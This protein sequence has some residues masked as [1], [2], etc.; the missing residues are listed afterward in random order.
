MAIT[1]H[2]MEN[3]WT[4]Y[5]HL[6]SFA[7]LPAPHTAERMTSVLLDCLM[8]W[9]IDSKISTITL[10]NYST[11]ES[12]IDKVKPKLL[13]AFLIKDG[14]MLH[15]R[16]GAHILNFTVRDGLLVIKDSIV[17]IR[18]SVA[19]WLAT[20]RRLEKIAETAKQLGVSLQKRLVL[21]CPTRWNSTHKMLETAIPNQIVFKRL[22]QR[23][24]SYISLPD[25]SMWEFPASVC[26][27]LSFC[28]PITK[29]FSGSNYPTSNVFF[30]EVCELKLRLFE[31]MV[32]PN[33]LISSMAYSM[34]LKFQKYWND[35]HD[36][37]TVAAVLDPKFKLEL[38][39]YYAE[40]F[41]SAEPNM[42]SFSVKSMMF[43]LVRYG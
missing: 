32:D 37:L 20:P 21:D 8:D 40:K 23:E 36:L 29:L 12:M 22:A 30:R 18:E 10:C 13:S 3:A 17:A 27:K 34:D 41:G 14:A 43:D 9:N 24:P 11:N 16:C 5:S 33:P 38:V 15:M 35:I 6:L 42:H 25:D 19:F 1:G 7:Y 4:L 2:Y 26:D 28:T 39:E 31:W